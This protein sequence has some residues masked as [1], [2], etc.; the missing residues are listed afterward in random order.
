METI[1]LLPKAAPKS[2]CKVHVKPALFQNP[3]GVNRTAVRILTRLRQHKRSPQLLSVRQ[4]SLILWASEEGRGKAGDRASTLLYP[5]QIQAFPA[6]F[7]PNSFPNFIRLPN[8]PS[9][10]GAIIGQIGSRVL[11]KSTLRYKF[12]DRNPS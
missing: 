7:P 8:D 2:S 4:P 12:L 10:A 9:A 11:L 1:A 5:R 6:T 3:L